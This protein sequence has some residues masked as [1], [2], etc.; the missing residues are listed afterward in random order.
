M[1]NFIFKGA[2]GLFLMFVLISIIVICSEKALEKKKVKDKNYEIEMT[3]S[4]ET[5]TEG[6]NK[7]EKKEERDNFDVNAFVEKETKNLA[8]V[9][10]KAMLDGQV[11]KLVSMLSKQILT[12]KEGAQIGVFFNDK[13]SPLLMKHGLEGK[14]VSELSD[15]YARLGLAF[16]FLR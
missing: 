13:L 5:E 14:N 11:T 6:F 12:D 2:K 10:N 9:E 16:D 3:T 8:K 15:L 1:K 7:K 4:H